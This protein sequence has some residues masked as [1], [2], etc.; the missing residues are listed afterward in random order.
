[1]KFLLKQFPLPPA[2][3]LL[4]GGSGSEQMRKLEEFREQRSHMSVETLLAGWE[5]VQKDAESGG[6]EEDEITVGI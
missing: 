1:L 2:Y 6:E 3:S 4:K 5:H